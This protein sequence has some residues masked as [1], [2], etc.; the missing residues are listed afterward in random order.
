MNS[1]RP[2][3]INIPDESLNAVRERVAAYPWHEMP[4]DGGWNY[5]TNLDYMKD[6][7][8]IGLMIMTGVNMKQLSIS[9]LSLKLKLM[10]LIC[11]LSMKLA[12]VL[13]PH[14]YS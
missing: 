1:C 9:F 5:G 10:I 2:F 3:K 8:S 6:S 12:V 14:L 7:L 11:I 4:D 13:H